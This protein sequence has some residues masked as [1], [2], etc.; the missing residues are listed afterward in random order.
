MA[1]VV[2][3]VEKPSAADRR[4]VSLNV[5][6]VSVRL[7]GPMEVRVGSRPIAV[8]GSRRRVLLALLAVA[9]PAPL[10]AETLGGRIWPDLPAAGTRKKVQTLVVR[11]RQDL[12]FDAIER[13]PG[14]YR[15]RC[16]VEDL[17][18]AHFDSLLSEA[19]RA[20][21]PMG[22]R[23]LLAAALDLWRGDPFD[24]IDCGWLLD[25][26]APRLTERYL[27]A[28][29]RRIEL[30]LAAGRHAESIAELRVLTGRYPLHEAGWEQLL[31]ALNSAGRPTEALAAYAEVRGLLATELG[32]EP[33]SQL[34]GIYRGLL[35]A[36]AERQPPEFVPQQLPQTVR[37]FIGRSA[38]LATLDALLPVADDAGQVLCA[39]IVGGGGVGKTALALR[40]AHR[41][42]HEFGDG[43][44]YLNLRGFGRTD[45]LEPMAALEALLRSLG[46]TADQIPRS[47]TA[48]TRAL[49]GRLSGKRTLVVLDN[50]RD[51]DQIRQL[52]PGLVGVR[53]PVLITSR[54]RLRD[55]NR[56][57]CHRTIELGMMPSQ[58]AVDVLTAALDETSHH[59]RAA[60]LAE[61]ARLCGHLPLALAIAGEQLA[62][63]PWATTAEVIDRLNASRPRLDAFDSPDDPT[64]SL[65]AVFSWS[66]R[67]LDT[68][69]AQLFRMLGQHT[70][71]D[72]TVRTAAA[73]VGTDEPDA[74]RKLRRLVDEHLLVTHGPNHFE[75]PDLLRSYALELPAPA[76]PTDDVTEDL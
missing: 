54:N 45:P 50:V 74:A 32:I 2:P 51:V 9:A 18:I 28:I 21:D 67:G 36:D 12:E 42:R 70:G 38:D 37:R 8:V 44:L 71:S 25:H 23:D 58:E 59:R 13:G 68:G 26:V 41:V 69:T 48:R 60:E 24:G 7:L 14:G 17:D 40:W 31:K 16:D 76:G 47:G 4:G 72:I 35:Q 61:L 3:R 63:Q 1:S 22:E 27:A 53:A 55:L 29:G 20:D 33:G 57:G 62:R 46:F 30:D 15:L 66:Y 10:L 34:Q 39:T 11:L 56:L 49:R 65:R 64:T 43:Q 5:H 52:L 75:L 19:A 6:K 73:L